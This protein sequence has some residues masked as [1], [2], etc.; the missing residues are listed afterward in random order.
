MSTEN[1]SGEIII[2]ATMV[3]KADYAEIYEF[4]LNEDLCVT[5]C[6]HVASLANGIVVPIDDYPTTLAK[7]LFELNHV[8][9]NPRVDNTKIITKLTSALTS[10]GIQVSNPPTQN[11]MALCFKPLGEISDTVRFYFESDTKCVFLSPTKN[12]QVVSNG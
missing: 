10:I 1:N 5:E 2:N 9:V 8:R 6:V 3:S 11:S 12:F 7:A 4:V